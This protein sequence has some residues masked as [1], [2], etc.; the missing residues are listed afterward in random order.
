MSTPPCS[1]FLITSTNISCHTYGTKESWVA[2]SIKKI[3]HNRNNISLPNKFKLHTTNP[4]FSILIYKIIYLQSSQRVHVRHLKWILQL[5]FVG[6]SYTS[7]F[8]MVEIECGYKLMSPHL[9][10]IVC[11]SL[12]NTFSN[13]LKPPWDSLWG[14]FIY[15]PYLSF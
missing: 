14:I 10:I 7:Y 3:L 9:P 12:S 6:P 15:F 5:V 2:I 11:F 1:F 8:M 4:T 13:F